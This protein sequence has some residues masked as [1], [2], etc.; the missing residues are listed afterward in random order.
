M[1]LITHQ[2]HGQCASC[3]LAAIVVACHLLHPVKTELSTN[4]SALESL[5]QGLSLDHSSAHL[6]C[7]VMKVVSVN[8]F[9]RGCTHL[10]EG[11]C[12]QCYGKILSAKKQA[13]R[14]LPRCLTGTAVWQLTDSTYVKEKV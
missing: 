8:P 6:D 3:A 10:H 14:H 2:L 9:H 5:F 12:E 1:C 11:Q 7:T 13:A 4:T